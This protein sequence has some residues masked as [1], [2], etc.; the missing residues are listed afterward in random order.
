MSDILKQDMER[1]ARQ[2]PTSAAAKQAEQQ[3]R[4]PAEEPSKLSCS[5]HVE[6]S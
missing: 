6:I 1:F 3:V 2:Q 5:L 4:R